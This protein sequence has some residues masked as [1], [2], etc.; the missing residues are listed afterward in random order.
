MDL[1]LFHEQRAIE[2]M[3]RCGLDVM[4]ARSPANVTYF[5]GYEC[6]IDPLMKQ[7]M[8][9]PGAPSD[10]VPLFA[11]FARQGESALVLE[12]FMGV[13]AVQT[14]CREL[15]LYGPA[16]P[17]PTGLPN[18]RIKRD[19]EID[20]PYLRAT[21]QHET[22]LA[23]LTAF[24]Q[25]HALTGARI[26]LEMERVPLAERDDLKRALPRAELLD[27]TNVIRLIRMVKSA[28]EQRRLARAAEI[29]EVAGFEAMSRARV[30]YRMQE[31]VQSY[32]TRVAELGA[33]FEH[34]AFSIGGYGMATQT[35]YA[36]TVDDMMFIDFGCIYQNYFSDTGTTLMMRQPG[37][38]E[39]ELFKAIRAALEEAADAMRPG[40]RAAEVHARM[41]AVQQRYALSNFSAEGHGLGVEMRDYPILKPDNGL[42]IRDDCVDVES[43]LPLEKGMVLNLEVSAF[44]PGFGA[45][46]TE[47]TFLVGDNG[48]RVL[49]AQPRDQPV[50]VDS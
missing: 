30:G 3:D 43:N 31:M 48:A 9:N 18:D 10:P 46:H 42:H 6:W 8:E 39:M 23:A 20:R 33:D 40:A 36:L 7:Y 28:E 38:G 25:N 1:M 34:F 14:S 32:R 13:N 5:T 19:S 47:Q 35:E 49:I 11:A 44:L 4:I 21:E 15:Y 17:E 45:W 29:A 12:Q 50:I 27:C 24:L 41:S 2:W 22:W 16:M 26:G 37:P